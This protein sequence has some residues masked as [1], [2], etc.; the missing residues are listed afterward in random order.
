MT[1]QIRNNKNVTLVDIELFEK[2]DF[3]ELRSVV[4]VKPYSELLLITYENDGPKA[5]SMIRA[6]DELQE[7]RGWLWEVYFMGEDN[8][9]EKFPQV[10]EEVKKILQKVCDDFD[11]LYMSID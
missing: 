4:C 8:K 5:M 7:L 3:V 2:E 11:G 6:F 9:A 10:L 1:L